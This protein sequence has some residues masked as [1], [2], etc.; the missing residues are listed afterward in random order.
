MGCSS[1]RNPLQ[2]RFRDTRT[3]EIPEN[4]RE[5]NLQEMGEWIAL[6]LSAKAGHAPAGYEYFDPIIR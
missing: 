6:P 5:Q 3:A 1:G 2:G 4:E